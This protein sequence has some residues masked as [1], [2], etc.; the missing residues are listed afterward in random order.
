MSLIIF[1]EGPL[2]T[3]LREEFR[4][5]VGIYENTLFKYFI[6]LFIIYSLYLAFVFQLAVCPVL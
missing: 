3:H 5:E 6:L 1:E 4:E 2:T